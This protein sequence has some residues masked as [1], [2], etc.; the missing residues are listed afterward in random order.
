MRPS[1]SAAARCP[2]PRRRPEPDRHAQHAALSSGAAGGHQ[3]H[4]RSRPYLASR[5][6]PGDR[7]AHP[8]RRGRTLGRDRAARSAHRVSHAAYRPSG[9]PQPRHHRRL[10]RVRRS[11]G[12][13]A[14]LSARAR[15]RGRDRRRRTGRRNVKADDFFKGLF[16][17]ALAPR[18]VLTAIRVP[19]AGAGD[20][21]SASPNSPAATATTRWPALP[22]AHA[23]RKAGSRT[24]GSPISASA[25]HPCAHPTPRA[26]LARGDIDAAVAALAEDLDPPDDV[27]ATGAVKK[28]LAGVLLRRVAQQLKEARQ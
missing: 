26:A 3:Q 15:R 1:F 24:S 9:D 20:A 22:P 13:V 4:R 14:G 6:E 28:H 5:R 16:E 2:H 7:R 12:R 17:T 23:P 27:Q 8:P 25:Q 19:A 18:D 11:G 21:R 10:D